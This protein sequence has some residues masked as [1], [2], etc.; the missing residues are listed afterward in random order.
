M[1]RVIKILFVV[2]MICL[3]A[4]PFV[5]CSKEKEPAKTL[6]EIG[7][8]ANNDATTTLT[9]NEDGTYSLSIAGDYYDHTDYDK[10]KAVYV[11]YE[12]ETV[13]QQFTELF[14]YE[15][16]YKYSGKTIGWITH[17]ADA[18]IAI[19]RLENCNHFWK[20]KFG[21]EVYVAIDGNTE[22]SGKITMFHYSETPT[23]DYLDKLRPNVNG[24]GGANDSG[25]IPL[26]DVGCKV[27]Y[28][29]KTHKNVDG[30]NATLKNA[31]NLN[32]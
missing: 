24:F 29:Q 18:W 14:K 9:F 15:Y 23:T 32:K 26:E 30:Y 8:F 21:G 11:H 2:L 1:K 4:L 7:K 3:M 27:E 17:S 10:Q 20:D 12:G 6:V 5:A 25:Y 13:N 16:K 22:E 31:A 19:Y 28:V